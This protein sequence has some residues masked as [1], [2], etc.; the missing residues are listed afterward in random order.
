MSAGF[1]VSDLQLKDFMDSMRANGARQ[2]GLAPHAT[3]AQLKQAAAAFEQILMGMMVDQMREA[4]PDSG[5]L[6]KEPGH[7]MYEQ[8]LDQEYLRNAGS[9]G[10]SLG[11]AEALER[12]FLAAQGDTPAEVEQAASLSNSDRPAECPTRV[13]DILTKGGSTGL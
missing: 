12:K 8:M 9:H 5:L 7:D 3:P 10:L 6:P 11:L 4:T 13:S 1:S 2:A